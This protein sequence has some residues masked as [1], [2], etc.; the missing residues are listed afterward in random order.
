MPSNDTIENEETEVDILPSILNGSPFKIRSN[1]EKLEILKKGRPLP[2]LSI[3]KRDGTRGCNRTFQTSWYSI[4]KWLCGK[5][6]N[7]CNKTNQLI[8]FKNEV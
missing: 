1:D 3:V 4:H 6:L 7:A 2:T 8:N 5:F